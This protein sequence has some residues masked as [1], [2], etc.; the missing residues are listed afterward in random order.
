MLW[1]KPMTSSISPIVLALF[2]AT[3]TTPGCI[4]SHALS[5][6]P[7]QAEREAIEAELKDHP[8]VTVQQRSQPGGST[9]AKEATP[10]LTMS[11]EGLQIESKQPFL[12]WNE[13]ES[14]ST[15][16]RGKGARIG[17]IAGLLVGA[18][19]GATVSATAPDCTGELLC[20]T[21]GAEGALVFGVS[22][23]LFGALVGVCTGT[24]VGY[25]NTWTTQSP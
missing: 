14:I 20:F 9:V 17:V 19:F 7:L 15:V 12:P 25:R 21:G 2:V 13:V 10:F 24:A 11:N 23:A 1:S 5:K 6:P 22:G 18:A 8:A 4:R 3:A 16:D